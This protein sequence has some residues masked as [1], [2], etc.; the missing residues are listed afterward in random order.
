MTEEVY[1]AATRVQKE[2]RGKGTEIQG[3]RRH[4]KVIVKEELECWQ[5]EERDTE[6]A[7]TQKHQKGKNTK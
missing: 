4:K 3:S 7:G 2:K 1:N 5:T 6:D